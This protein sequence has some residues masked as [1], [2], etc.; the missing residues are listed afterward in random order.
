[1]NEIER[2]FFNK[3]IKDQSF[4]MKNYYSKARDE[5][6]WIGIHDLNEVKVVV[7]LTDEKYEEIDYSELEQFITLDNKK[8][9]VINTIV[10]TK[11]NDYINLNNIPNKIVYNINDRRV[12]YS[13]NQNEKIF[14][15]YLDIINLNKLSFKTSITKYPLTY[16]LIAI[17]II[18]FF[19]TAIVSNNV[20]NIDTMTLIKFGGRFNTLINQGEVWRLFTANFLH[21]GLSHIIFNIIA[22][23]I[24]GR[25]VEL[26][27]GRAR[28][29]AIYIISSLGCSILSYLLNPDVVSVGASGAIFGLLA[30]V[31]YFAIREKDRIGKGVYKEILNVLI[32]NIILGFLMP[33]IDMYGHLGGFISGFVLSVLLLN[34]KIELEG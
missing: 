19:I 18:I 11:E 3:L 8:A 34:R 7:I 33:N 15:Q 13:Y 32:L 22:L 28:Y 31:L 1:M 12:I 16:A 14:T 23:N 26:I 21:G 5:E 10:L 2:Q 20:Y 17:N 27:Y 30:A 4:Y 29:L 24:L 9:V 6:K 25:E